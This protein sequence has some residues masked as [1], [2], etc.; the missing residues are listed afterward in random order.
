TGR[1]LPMAGTKQVLFYLDEQ[2]KER[3]SCDDLQWIVERGNSRSACPGKDSGYRG[4][5]F[6]CTRKEILWEVMGDK[7]VDL[8]VATCE[9]LVALPDDFL[10]FRAL[11]DRLGIEGFKAW[12]KARVGKRRGGRTSPE[13]RKLRR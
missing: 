4:I 8:T 3:L 7:C 13:R 12:L 2:K 9:L 5:S 6:V 1:L 10:T 11:L